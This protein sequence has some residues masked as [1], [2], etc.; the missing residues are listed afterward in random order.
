MTTVVDRD[1][2]QERTSLLSSILSA[3]QERLLADHVSSAD[4]RKAGRLLRPTDYDLVVDERVHT[5]RCG[6]PTCSNEIQAE[7]ATYR[8]NPSEQRVYARPAVQF[9][10]DA[11]MRLSTTFRASLSEEPIG[12]R[13]AVLDAIDG[14]TNPL[15]TALKVKEKPLVEHAPAPPPEE[16]VISSSPTGT[17]AD[18]LFELSIAAKEELEVSSEQHEPD[19]IPIEKPVLE[20]KES[21]KAL[22]MFARLFSVAMRWSM[23]TPNAPSRTEADRERLSS[24]LKSVEP[25]L[26]RQLKWLYAH[27]ES[28][29][30]TVFGHVRTYIVTFALDRPVVAAV[31]WS[32]MSVVILYKVLQSV[33]G[34]DDLSEFSQTI[35]PTV[36]DQLSLDEIEAVAQVLPEPVRY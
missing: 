22:S 23:E 33:G 2:S 5:R 35:G 13:K 14:G 27:D 19:V 9:C 10:S 29:A 8:I 25:R 4:L 17:F 7:R 28:R 1:V 31:D 12:Q 20:L 16:S 32:A 34:N 18:M 36:A 11:C 6:L 3:V 30:S 24:V 15:P 21:D 26:Q